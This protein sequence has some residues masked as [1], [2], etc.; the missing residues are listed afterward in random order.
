MP[1]SPLVARA[2]AVLATALAIVAAGLVPGAVVRPM[3]VPP[4]APLP[5]EVTTRDAELEV[6]VRGGEA[7]VRAYSVLG[8]RAYIAA[9][10]ATRDGGVVLR[11]LPQ[12]EHWVVAEAPGMARASSMVIT[13]IGRRR[14]ELSLEPEKTLSV[15]VRDESGAAREGVEIEVSAAE[16]VPIGARTDAAGRARIGRLR[17][18]PWIV[19]VR[20]AGYEPVVR[21]GVREG[22][23][24]D[25]VLRRLGAFVVTVVDAAGAPAGRAR[26]LITSASLHPA[27]I[28]EA[29]DRGVVRI[30][31]LEAGAYALR[32]TRGATASPVEMAA[33]L[34]VGEEKAVTLKLQPA[35]TVAVRVVDDEGPN[36][37]PVSGAQVTLVEGG[38]SPFPI[39]GLTDGAGRAVIGPVLAGGVTVSVS[40]AGFAPRGPVRVPEP[41]EGDLTVVL[42]RSG[43]IEGRVVDARGFAVDGASVRVVGTDF[44]GGPVDEDPERQGFRD[45]LF[46]A[47]LSGPSPLVKVGELGVVPGPVPPIPPPGAAILP[48]APPTAPRGKEIEPWT[49]RR[50]GTF[51]LAPVPAGR[52]RLLVRHPQFVEAESDLVTLGPGA[53]VKVEVVM[54]RGGS[55]EGRVV[56]EGGRGVDGAHVLLVPT[57]AGIEKSTRTG[58]DGTFAFASVPE[59][60]TLLVSYRDDPSDYGARA[61]VTVKEG[62]TERVSI[63]LPERR[64]PLEVIVKDARGRPVENAQVTAHSADAHAALRTTGFTDARGRVELAGARG[65]ATRL[66]VRAPDLAPATREVEASAARAEVSLVAAESLS[67]EVRERRAALAGADVTVFSDAGAT[68]ART[69][70]DG[71]FRVRDLAPGAVKIRIRKAG[72][73]A[74]TLDARIEPTEG[75]RPSELRPV[76]LSEEGVVEGA[77]VDEKGRPVPF[78]RVGEDGVPV[79]LAAGQLPPG[80]ALCDK[81]GRFELREL[82]AGALTLEGYSPEE[83]R[84]RVADVKVAAG[85]TTSGVKIQLARGE[86]PAKD[87]KGA[88]GVA[89]TLGETSDPREVVV[90]RVAEGSEAERAGLRPGDVVV[91]VDGAAV[92][93]IEEARARLSGPLALDV[94]VRIRRG[95]RI[96]TRRVT[97]ETVRR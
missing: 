48:G 20:A 6:Q 61:E 18:G 37:D 14:V 71:T 80:S 58:G 1:A 95:S 64:P 24:V 16:P 40:A 44:Y 50:D 8:G 35:I 46:V 90:A 21:R 13:E 17:A 45:A 70:A 73:A 59:S 88:G 26:V 65:I 52:V 29:D 33:P 55:L 87:A 94:L 83:G 96:E 47:R 23:E 7:T 36:A 51:R 4:V 81:S 56:D 97:R 53:E 68:H 86:G 28:A 10:G 75:R 93:T 85:R 72:F 12:G 27:R 5:V 43:A 76:E 11:G 31:S 84:G 42:S 79:F 62:K 15:S 3:F 66:E 2:L 22:E 67:G 32:A 91:D 74:V 39:E 30:G 34:G 60:V 9:E 92:R 49:T 25:V 41:L 77:V 89:V 82:R 69:S 38:L 57:Q 19:R 54:Q 63:K 78:A